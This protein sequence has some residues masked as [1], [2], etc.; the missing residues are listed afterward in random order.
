M[1][2]FGTLPDHSQGSMQ[3]NFAHEHSQSQT[4]VTPNP[5]KASAHTRRSS[6]FSD[7]NASPELRQKSSIPALS[8]TN[9]NFAGT[10]NVPFESELIS[11]NP[12]SNV[13][14]LNTSTPEP[15]HKPLEDQTPSKPSKIKLKPIVHNPDDSTV[16]D[17]QTR[18]L[19]SPIRLVDNVVP[20]P[21]LDGFKLAGLVD[22]FSSTWT[23]ENER[24]QSF[25]SRIIKSIY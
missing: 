18:T 13:D 9:L 11:E 22:D 14:D 1:E 21:P 3:D 4:D 12:R 15:Q 23:D 24:V 25:R 2:D 20:S 10:A 19:R 6:A 16:D 7:Y 8:S 5:V 17:G